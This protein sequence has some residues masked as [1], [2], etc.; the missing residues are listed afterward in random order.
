LIEVKE[1]LRYGSEE[2]P[3]IRMNLFS[4]ARDMNKW[5]EIK[6][7]PFYKEMVEEVASKAERY[8]KEPIK[9]I[10]YSKYRLFSENGNRSEYQEYYYDRRARLN[11]FAFLSMLYGESKHIEA[12]EDTIWAI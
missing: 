9:A 12:L 1:A 3:N 7:S 2:C 8:L 6:T 10:P 4:E 5:K 11:V